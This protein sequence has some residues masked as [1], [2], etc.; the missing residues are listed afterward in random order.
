MISYTACFYI[1]PY[2][3]DFLKAK[4]DGWWI[5]IY[6]FNILDYNHCLLNPIKLTL[7]YYSM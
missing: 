6:Y 7:S 5:L 4:F 1:K 2:M 3:R